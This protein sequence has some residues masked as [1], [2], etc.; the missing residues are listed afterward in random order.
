MRFCNASYTW[1]TFQTS[2]LPAISCFL[3]RNDYYSLQK[4]IVV[5]SGKLCRSQ[6]VHGLF[7]NMCNGKFEV[8]KNWLFVLLAVLFFSDWLKKIS[9]NFQAG[10]MS[11][12]NHETLK[13]I[14][15][16][17]MLGLFS[18]CIDTFK[19]TIIGHFKIILHRTNFG[20]HLWLWRRI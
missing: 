9:E 11:L 18:K 4:L 6:I 8:F 2:A 17:K 12:R 20:F 10:K 14:I 3:D 13:F 16:S 1:V 19:I 5:C 7:R 15:G